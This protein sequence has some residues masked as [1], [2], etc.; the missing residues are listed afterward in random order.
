MLLNDSLLAHSVS[1][2]STVLTIAP[3]SC[4]RKAKTTDIMREF[5]K[6]AP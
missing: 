5:Q 2:V 3:S 4:I 6:D 1:A